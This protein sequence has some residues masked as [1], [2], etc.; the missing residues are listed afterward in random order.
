MVEFYGPESHQVAILMD[1]AKSMHPMDMSLVA[2]AA[3]GALENLKGELG[4]GAIG[5]LRQ[6]MAG[7][8]LTDFVQLAK[9]TLDDPSDR[10]KNVAA[11]LTA[12]AFEDTIRRMEESL[13]GVVGR[14]DL[15]DVIT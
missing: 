3:R 8:V 1:I 15:Q 14:G 2:P 5:S 7:D 9:A 6:R 11:V 4:A 10:A 12:A 13:A